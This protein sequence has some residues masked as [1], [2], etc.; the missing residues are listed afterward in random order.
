VSSS[1]SS[2]VRPVVAGADAASSSSS[3]SVSN[4]GAPVSYVVSVYYPHVRHRRIRPPLSKMQE[5]CRRGGGAS[6]DMR[7]SCAETPAFSTR[8][9]R[10]PR[11]HRR[12]GRRPPPRGAAPQ[13]S[14]GPG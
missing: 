11:P 6:L 7:G 8:R 13:C 4:M 9:R 3:G 1:R 5:N 14:R 12:R 2:G 10:Q